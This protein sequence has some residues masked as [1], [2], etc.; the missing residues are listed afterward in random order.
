M[1]ILDRAVAQSIADQV[2]ALPG[3]AGLHAGKFGEI[4]LLYPGQKV[5]GLRL[6][7]HSLEI[8]ISVSYGA[9]Q[10]LDV[11][12][13]VLDYLAKTTAQVGA[14]AGLPVDVYIEDIQP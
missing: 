11:D 1:L 2:A 12:M 10:Q 9:C 4:A 5:P 14:T 6:T 13:Q 8:H 7:D 3:V